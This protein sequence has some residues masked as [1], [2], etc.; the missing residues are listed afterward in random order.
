MPDYLTQK[1]IKQF[2]P[3]IVLIEFVERGLEQVDK[4]IVNWETPS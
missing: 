3:D 1:S 4:L 2:K